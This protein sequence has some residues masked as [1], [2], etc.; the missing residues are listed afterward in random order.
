MTNAFKLAEF[1]QLVL[2]FP[3]NLPQSI[4][5][6]LAH[7]TEIHEFLSQSYDMASEDYRAP[8]MVFSFI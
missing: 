4:S 6:T 1:I 7:F 3:G 8:V 5:F 2:L